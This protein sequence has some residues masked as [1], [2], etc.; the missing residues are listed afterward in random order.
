MKVEFETAMRLI[1]E[2][3]ET[4]R[5][6]SPGMARVIEVASLPA[7]EELHTW[8]LGFRPRNEAEDRARNGLICRV[9][10]R[11]AQLL[12]PLTSLREIDA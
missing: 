10:A 7:A 2:R 1:R 9:E 11:L 12:P 4:G 3:V 6:L 8:L 5:E